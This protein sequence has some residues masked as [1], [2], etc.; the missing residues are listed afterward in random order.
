MKIIITLIVLLFSFTFS[1]TETFAQGVN[2]PN[3]FGTIIYQFNGQYYV[4]DSQNIIISSYTPDVVIKTAL[5]RGGDIY[6][7]GGTY[8]LTNDFSGFNLKY[9]SYLK[10][11]SDASIVVPSGYSGYVFR[12]S[13]YV[14]H[15]VV[16][17]GHIY[18][19]NP[20]K[21]HWIGIMMQGGPGGVYFNY[22]ENT[23]ITDPQIVIDFNATT[24]QWVNAN[25][26]VNIKGWNFVKGI[27]FDFKGKHT[28]GVDGFDANTFRDSQ[29]QGG[30]MTTYGVKDIKHSFNAFYNVQ[31]WDL[32]A[33]S[34]SSTI[35]PS[36]ENTIIIGGQMTYQGFS[37]SGTNTL[38][39]D[40]WDSKIL[41]NST[42]ISS[43]I[44]GT[45]Q[46][47]PNTPT[48]PLHQV[49]NMSIIQQA[50][51]DFVRGNH[52]QLNILPGQST[53]V[54][55]YGTVDNPTGGSMQMSVSRPDGAVEQI[56]ADV[57]SAGVFY[58]PL[59]FDK[60]SLT[61]QY[62]IDG[63]YQN[64]NL[65]TLFLNVTANQGTI[66]NQ[67]SQPNIGITPSSES[68]TTL[69]ARI[70][71]DAQLWSQ[72]EISNDVF[73]S[74]IQYLAKIGIIESPNQNQSYLHHTISI[75]IWLKN[76]AIWW[77]NGQISDQDFFSGIQYLLNSGIMTMPAG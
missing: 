69:S 17:G 20:V 32:P 58:Y 30:P 10:M 40:A 15:C 27:E 61:G 66:P 50:Q 51:N 47:Q 37:D 42:M 22:I 14:G 62:R 74:D 63:S 5:S 11:A 56:H 48:L 41:S 49:M 25:T 77:A 72:G 7:A 29:F 39:L 45:Y 75:P 59:M 4:K 12:F 64:S 23:V 16:D 52:G 38:V 9:G 35:D 33:S 43:I 34:I 1:F 44:N 2:L 70:K 71:N 13:N 46:A 60:N 57:T 28:D 73:L 76:N 6:I 65:G 18:E 19:A 31:F 53:V 24:G 54:N 68:N 3:N 8:T 26:F 55:I 21:R 36:A 67:S